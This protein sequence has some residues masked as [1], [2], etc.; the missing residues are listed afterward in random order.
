MIGQIKISDLAL[1]VLLIASMTAVGAM[2]FQ[3]QM[4]GLK[5]YCETNKSVNISHEN[6]MEEC[7]LTVVNA[8]YGMGACGM[9]MC[10]HSTVIVAIIAAA[11]IIL[12]IW[13]F[14]DD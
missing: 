3:K 9:N 6:W 5:E 8:E 12:F 10:W 13:W 2:I 7:N 1:F 14:A 11:L 4:G